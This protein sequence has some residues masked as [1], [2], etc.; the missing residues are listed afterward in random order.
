[1]RKTGERVWHVLIQNGRTIGHFATD[2]VYIGEVPTLVFEWQP[3]GQPAPNSTAALNR[4]YLHEVNWPQA[5][6][7]Y[8]IPIHDPRTT[9]RTLQ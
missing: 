7:M 3:D 6:W 2:L 1:M 9:S 4:Q 8:E 5:R